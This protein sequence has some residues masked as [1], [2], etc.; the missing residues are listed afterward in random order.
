MIPLSRQLRFYLRYLLVTQRQLHQSDLT[1]H[2]HD[3]RRSKRLAPDCLNLSSQSFLVKGG[4]HQSHR[5]GELA[6]TISRDLPIHLKPKHS[7][8]RRL[9]Y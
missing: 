1:I 5:G 3:L 7:T 8:L 6:S 2:Q 9:R 4:L